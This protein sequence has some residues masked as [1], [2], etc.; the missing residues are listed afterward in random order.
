M[1]TADRVRAFTARSHQTLEKLI[2]ELIRDLRTRDDYT[3]LLGLFYSYFSGIENLIELLDFGAELPDFT[4]RRKALLISHDISAL[5]GQVRGVVQNKFL[6]EIRNSFQAFGALYVMEGSTLGGPHIV[7]MIQKKLGLKEDV[8][9]FFS[10][11]G[12]QNKAMWENFKQVLNGLSESE[13]DINNVLT[14]AEDTFQKFG[15]WIK[16]NEHGKC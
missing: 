16:S 14:G 15:E 10:G 7:Q 11:Y 2:V 1:S 3:H 8:F 5:Q 12:D 6:P 13:D 9:R 4:K